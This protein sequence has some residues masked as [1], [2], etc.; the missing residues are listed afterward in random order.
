M[1]QVVGLDLQ[2]PCDHALVVAEQADL[3]VERERANVQ[4]DRT[5]QRN[6]VVHAHV[7][8]VDEVR[9]VQGDLHPAARRLG[10]GILVM[11]PF[12]GGQLLDKN[13]SP[14]G[15][16]L[17]PVQCLAYNLDRPAVLSCIPGAA[18]K[19]EVKSL[20]GYTDASPEQKS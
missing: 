6:R 8:G 9:L 1:G 7:L 11:K 15:V 14:I 17:T 10:L 5:D 19:D 4:V 2:H 12:A 13:R 18:D 20:L 16:A 3:G